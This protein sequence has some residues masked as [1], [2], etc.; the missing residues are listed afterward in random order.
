VSLYPVMLHG[1]AI[2]AVVVGGGTVATRKALG[3]L[4]AGATVRV[5]APQPGDAIRGA[6]DEP[7]LRLEARAFVP[8]DLDGAT[9]VVAAT[10]DAAV[11]AE[12]AR[13]ARARGLLVNVADR[14]DA[15]TFS[16]A[17]VHRAGRLVV[18]VGAG[19]VPTAAARV[20][21][22]IAGRLD[23]RY[24]DAIERLAAVRTRLLG[25]GDADGWRRAAA[26]L[27]G[28]D[29]AVAVESGT[30]AERVRRWD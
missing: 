18:A 15:G 21:D 29:F 1:E 28:P 7:R 26:D 4:E 24:A 23:A 5:V 2:V 30:F 3:L 10:D 14:P 17:A 16:T 9:L 13:L 11:N 27:T 25:S 20:R 8:D 12:V 19:G 6:V 22:L